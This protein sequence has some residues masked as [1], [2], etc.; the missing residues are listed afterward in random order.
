MRKQY[1]STILDTAIRMLI[2]FYL[3]YGVYVLIKGPYSPG[4][5]FQSGVVFAASVLLI[6]LVQ[7]DNVN[8]GISKGTALLVAAAGAFIYAGIGIA[9]MLWGGNYLD[10]GVLPF[11]E[12]PPKIRAWGT[13]GIEAGVTLGVAG[14]FIVIF[15]LLIGRE[16]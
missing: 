7:G 6:N 4:G 13:L 5:G 15:N 1:G 9:A 16:E 3:V 8:W 12:I 11:G 10:Y 14:T 2:R